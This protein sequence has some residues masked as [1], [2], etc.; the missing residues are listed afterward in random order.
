[1]NQALLNNV[2]NNVLLITIIQ[3]LLQKNVNFAIVIVSNVL[4]QT[5]INV[6]NVVILI[7]YMKAL[8]ALKNVQ[9]SNFSLKLKKIQEFATLVIIHV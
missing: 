2:Y 5:K 4:V 1:M 3:I 6:Q 7:F 8:I 9:N